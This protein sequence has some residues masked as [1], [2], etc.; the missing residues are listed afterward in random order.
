[1]GAHP[2]RTVCS[3]NG[4]PLACNSTGKLEGEYMRTILTLIGILWCWTFASAEV[5]N[6]EF[7]FTPFVG[8]PAGSKQVETVPGRAEIFVNNIPIGEQ[9]VG[10]REVPVLFEQREIAPAV[11]VPA[12]SLGSVLRK[13]KNIIRVVFEA[14]DAKLPYQAR[15]SWATVTDQVT[16]EESG[17]GQL[18]ATNQ[19]DEGMENKQSTGTVVFE[20]AFAADFAID[21]PWHHYPPVTD[22]SDSDKKQIAKL[23]QER[24]AVFG[25]DFSAVYEILKHV[26]SIKS[27][28][29]KQAKCFE[30]GYAAGVRFVAAPA[31]AFDYLLTGN[32]E[33]VVRS[34]SGP[35]FQPKDVKAIERIKDE[36]LQM[37]LYFALSAVYP[38]RLVVV[39]NAD[40]KWHVVY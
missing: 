20:R 18:R 14:D 17:P 11:W 10:K 23:V 1:M 13:G 32:A 28:E 40:G 15:F 25:P 22:L 29:V 31:G 37:C 24:V 4:T 8:D 7:T 38:P 3:D 6:V 39:R 2:A 26:P 30:K 19:Q 16:R 12:K 33:V 36:D 5:L 27:E 9:K 35:L 34:K 21:H